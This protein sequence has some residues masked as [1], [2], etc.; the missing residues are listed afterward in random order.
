MIKNAVMI[1]LMKVSVMA[2][3]KY[4][5]G[6]HEVSFWETTE[7]RQI[8]LLLSGVSVGPVWQVG[9]SPMLFLVAV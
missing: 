7:N 9:A 3:F 8:D 6:I 2:G 4:Y 5:L 1:M